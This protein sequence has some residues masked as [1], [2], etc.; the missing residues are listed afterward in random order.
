M[1]VAADA[2]SSGREGGAEG[3]DAGSRDEQKDAAVA[4]VQRDTGTDVAPPARDAEVVPTAL[5]FT[6]PLL[7]KGDESAPPVA[8]WRLVFSDDF[9]GAAIDESK[10]RSGAWP[11]KFGDLKGWDAKLAYVKDGLLHLRIEQRDDGWY[12]GVVDTG[13]G[14]Q[15]K[16]A[17]RFGLV[18]VRAK[19]PKGQGL[20]SALWHMPVDQTY[21]WWPWSGEIDLIEH[22]GRVEGD[23]YQRLYTT[24]HFTKAD[25][26]KGQTH[27]MREGTDWTSDF[28]VYSLLWFRSA[29]GKKVV[30]ATAVDNM[31]IGSFVIDV[32]VPPT[33]SGGQGA[34]EPD[35]GDAGSPF[36]QRFNV[37]LNLAGGGPWAK[38]IDAAVDG[39][40][41]LVDWVRWWQPTAGEWGD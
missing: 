3:R 29:P 10:W 13:M 19:L 12:G 4:E 2:A 31:P 22:L 5:P 28:H 35:G 41:L 16:F 26:T 8:A 21:G 34:T 24:L 36:D 39:S 20:W 1:L 9:A 38:A 27:H 40:E 6:R 37:I 7:S 17:A 11:D 30:I 18:E 33:P 14:D 15:V 23:E 32:E 25:R